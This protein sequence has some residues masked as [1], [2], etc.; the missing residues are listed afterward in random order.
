MIKIII[1]ADTGID[2]SIAIL[3]ALKNPEIK[4]MGICTGYGNTTTEQA[5]ENTLRLIQLAKPGYDVPVVTGARS[6]LKGEW[7]GPVYHVHGNNGIGNA[8]I[9]MSNQ[10]ILKEDYRDFIYRTAKENHGELVIVTLGRLTNLA[11]TL[12]RH[13]N[14]PNNVKKLVMM[15]GTVY[16]PGN[17]SPCAEANIWGDPEAADKVFV[18]ELDITMVGLDVTTKTRLTMDHI[19]K[20]KG[21]CSGENSMLVEYLHRALDFYM[22]FYLKQDGYI[23]NY[24][25]HD[26][27]AVLVATRPDLVKTQRMKARVELGGSYSRGRVIT[28]LR[29]HSFDGNYINM[30]LDVDGNRAVEE[31]LSVFY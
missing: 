12:E 11:M 31:L 28:D 23:D 19:I 29:K 15:G 26:P 5:A 1:D 18:S 30:C 25:V 20:L 13:P 6:P 9:P 16:A 10:E 3:Y 4:V 17:V 14:L 2:D 8:E 22:D 7:D 24:P 21:K 27:L